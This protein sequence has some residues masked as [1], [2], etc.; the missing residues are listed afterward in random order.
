MSAAEIA[1]LYENLSLADEDGAI[2]EISEEVIEDGIEDVDRCLVGKVLSRKRVNREAFKGLIE[3]IWSPFGQVEVELVGLNTFKFYFINREVR[4][5]VWHK[6]PWHFG[7]SLIV[8]EKPKGSGDISKL[9]F[10]KAD[11]W[12]Q[13]HDIPIM[14]MN[15]RTTKWLTEQLVK[16]LIYPQNLE[17]AGENKTDEV[18]VVT[19]KYERLPD[20]CYVCGRIGHGIK[21]CIDEEARKASLEGLP[22]KFGSW[23]KASTS[24]QSNYKFNSQFA[25]SSL[26]RG[27]SLEGSHSASR[28]A[29][30]K[31]AEKEVH[32]VTLVAGGLGPPHV[33]EMCVDGPGPGS[34]GGPKALCLPNSE[35]IIEHSA[36]L[37]TQDLIDPKVSHMVDR[38]NKEDLII[39]V[40]TTMLP[41]DLKTNNPMSTPT[42]KKKKKKKK[43]NKQT[44]KKWK[45]S[46]REGHLCQCSGKIPN[47]LHMMLKGLGNPHA[48]A[49]LLRLLKSHSL[50][51]VFSSETK[52]NGRKT[53][54]FRNLLGFSGCISVDSMG[55]SGGFMLL[56]K[57]SLDA[58][59][60][61]FFAG[62]IDA[63]IC[64]KDGFRW[65]FLGC[66]AI[67]GGPDL[68]KRPWFGVHDSLGYLGESQLLV[69]LSNGESNS[70]STDPFV[71]TTPLYYVNAPPH[72][73]SAYT[74][75]A[76][77]AIA[78]FQILLM[79]SSS[80]QLTPSM[81]EFYSRVLANVDIMRAFIVLTVKSTRCKVGSEVA[82]KVFLFFSRISTL[83]RTSCSVRETQPIFQLLKS[84]VTE[85]TEL[86]EPTDSGFGLWILNLSLALF[87]WTLAGLSK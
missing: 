61:S 20:F 51:L 75:I 12:V 21:E 10:T 42:K 71:L 6:G 9:G 35:L 82:Y 47:P 3:Q 29:A 45:R 25:G 50:Y 65:Q 52:L 13:I 2:H 55:S 48:F 53:E 78:R 15:R 68:F 32:Q 24:E 36:M 23:L 66:L 76:A 40:D 31:I 64:M 7:K 28:T 84:N 83:N 85:S 57:D 19:L 56:W 16:L 80:G 37:R 11:F 27:R 43:T 4:N 60:L 59:V 49:A 46:T 39:D 34:T 8:L 14:C 54:K 41:K 72:M 5:R 74:A 73:G 69:K 81:K 70:E 17:S 79:T 63:R 18:T 67:F 44:N 38:T 58:F 87:L 1:Q 33:D 26:E 62:H 30:T 22:N 86:A 77:D